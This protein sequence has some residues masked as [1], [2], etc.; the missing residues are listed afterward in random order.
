[1][2][3][4]QKLLILSSLILIVN[5]S[6]VEK[7]NN[8]LK[9]IAHRGGSNLAPENTLAA[10]KKAINLDVDMIEIDVHLSKDSNIIV[11]HDKTI[12]RTTD[13]TGEIKNMTLDEIKKYDAGSW[14]N[15][16][17]QDERVPTLD[18]TFNAIKGQTI[19][20]IE[21]KDGDERYPGL[22]KRVVESIHKHNA[23]TWTVVQSF[24]KNS[25]LRVKKMD[26]LI[27]TY[28]LVSSE[29]DGL[30]SDITEKI[31]ANR[32]IVKQF[33]GIAAH[34]SHLDSANVEIM[35]KA[36]FEVFTW[37]VDKP[38]DMIKIIDINI[39]GIITNSPGKLKEILNK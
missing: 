31:N 22:E 35:H 15:E 32:K 10:F 14:F 33:D 36:G 39:D 9:I 2:K 12:D 20:L 18:E 24:N 21:I 28:Y 6:E 3:I 11:I 16:S 8:Q 5:C 26:P 23:N 19:L 25:I 1:M 37:T 30:Y 4:I 29:F 27:I 13:G 34:Y 38:E 7:D 17:F